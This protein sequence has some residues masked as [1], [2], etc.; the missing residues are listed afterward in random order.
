[1][2]TLLAKGL[3]SLSETNFQSDSDSIWFLSF[4][5]NIQAGRS[6][7]KVAKVL[8]IV[9]LSLAAVAV[10]VAVIVVAVTAS[11]T[12]RVTAGVTSYAIDNYGGCSYFTGSRMISS[13]SSRVAY[14]YFSTYYYYYAYASY[15]S[16]Y[17]Y[18]KYITSSPSYYSYYR[19][20]TSPTYYSYRTVGSYSYSE[21]S[22]RYSLSYSLSYSTNSYC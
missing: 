13:S 10:I 3:I 5:G 19:Y 20:T 22:I 2:T 12:S 6:N 1:M 11:S 18:Y 4:A 14:N 7:A 9:S 16:Y 21:S 17:S 8:N 15:P